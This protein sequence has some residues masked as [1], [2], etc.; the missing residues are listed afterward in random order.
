MVAAPSVFEQMGYM[1]GSLA[2]VDRLPGIVGEARASLSGT[3]ARF[4]TLAARSYHP[5]MPQKPPTGVAIP[6][7]T[8]ERGIEPPRSGGGA[9]VSLAALGIAGLSRR[10]VGI[11]VTALLAIW[12]VVSFA[13]QVSQAARAADRAS[14]EQATNEALVAHVT[15]LRDELDLVQTQRWILQQ[16]RAYGLGST[17]E[18]PFEIAADAPTIAPD[19]PGSAARRIGTVVE[20]R[21]PLDSWLD[22]LFG[23]GG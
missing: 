5:A 9:T 21:S 17:S 18:R 4:D 14:Q 3:P 10:R 20:Q 23:P 6:G 19:A 15:A 7:A 13:G 8:D 16:A 22:A 1:S 12:I 2:S 11:A